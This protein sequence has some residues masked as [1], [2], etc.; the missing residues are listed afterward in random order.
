MKPEYIEKLV[1]LLLD[2]KVDINLKSKNLDTY[3][4]KIM[5]SVVKKGKCRELISIL[6]KFFPNLDFESEIEVPREKLFEIL[7]NRE[8]SRLLGV[9]N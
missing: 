7:S 2:C 1:K 9:E 8:I 6:E 3:I 5:F 4:Y